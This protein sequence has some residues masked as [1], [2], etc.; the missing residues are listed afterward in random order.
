MSIVEILKTTFEQCLQKHMVHTHTVWQAAGS[1][2]QKRSRQRAAVHNSRADREQVSA[3]A[4]PA[5]REC[6]ASMWTGGHRKTIH[7]QI[8]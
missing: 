4:E 3:A 6:L 7:L 2:A 1:G 8:L 5:V